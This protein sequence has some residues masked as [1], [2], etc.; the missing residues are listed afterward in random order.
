MIWT[1]VTINPALQRAEYHVFD[2]FPHDGE[3]AYTQ[4]QSALPNSVIVALIKGTHKTST[5]V[6]N[7][8]INVFC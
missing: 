1:V 4:A 5:Y 3:A 6:P 8:A 7:K 2:S